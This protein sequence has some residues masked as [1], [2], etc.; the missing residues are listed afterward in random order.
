[1]AASRRWLARIAFALV[2]AVVLVSVLLP[3]TDL[4]WMR[5][6]WAWFNRPMLWIEQANSRVNLVHL[7][8]FLLLGIAA[9]AALPGWNAG[10]MAAA[11][12]LLGIATELLQIVVPGRDPRIADVVVDI[13]AGM[14]GWA[15]AHVVARCLAAA[16][17]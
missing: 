2:L 9:R 8:L 12:L 5:E 17:G 16:R 14:A 11:L 7:V 4:A 6:H 15:F 10:R 13:V 3:N 1:M